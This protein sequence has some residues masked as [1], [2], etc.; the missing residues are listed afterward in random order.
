MLDVALHIALDGTLH[1]A[2]HQRVQLVAGAQAHAALIGSAKRCY[3]H[4]FY[5]LAFAG[6][7]LLAFAGGHC[8]ALAIHHE[9]G[10]PALFIFRNHHRAGTAL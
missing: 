6:L 5:L 3:L 7:A 8:Y 10:Q 1:F 4:Y 2:A 9:V